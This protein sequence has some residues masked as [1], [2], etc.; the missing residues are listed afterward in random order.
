MRMQLQMWMWNDAGMLR[1][2]LATNYGNFC[3]WGGS[4][5]TAK[6]AHGVAARIARLTRQPVDA[7][8]ETARRDYATMH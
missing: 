3:T 4:L 8:Y 7:V 6:R 5:E 2:Y 1:E